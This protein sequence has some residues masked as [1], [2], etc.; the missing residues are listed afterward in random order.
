M[1]NFQIINNLMGE[2]IDNI[3]GNENSD[4]D[5][6][7]Q[8]QKELQNREK[9]LFSPN[10]E[11]LSL[12]SAPPT[13]MS[14]SILET[15]ENKLSKPDHLF[16]E[17]SKTSYKTEDNSSFCS[18]N[19]LCPEFVLKTENLNILTPSHDFYLNKMAANL[20]EVREKCPVDFAS[21]QQNET[22]ETYKLCE[23][24]NCEMEPCTNLTKINLEANNVMNVF[25][26]PENNVSF[27]KGD[28]K[29]QV[30]KKCDEQLLP[31]PI[32]TLKC[33]KPIETFIKV[34]ESLN[35]SSLQRQLKP[36]LDS[37]YESNSHYIDNIIQD[38]NNCES[39][40]SVGISDCYSSGRSEK[41]INTK[42][43]CLKIFKIKKFRS[44]RVSPVG[45][46]SEVSSESKVRKFASNF[47]KGLR[48]SFRNIREVCRSKR[49]TSSLVF[50]CVPMNLY[51]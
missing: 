14:N 19:Q 51:R 26:I 47:I 13:K 12:T 21:T 1:D 43:T 3:V 44:N 28:I 40:S 9:V 33:E 11:T 16:P 15:S 31:I 17:S 38:V 4:H 27:E 50:C 2:M 23:S 45:M 32:Q 22:T 48:K 35:I 30:L 42:K 7:N 24:F 8:V 39:I 37:N 18:G 25:T 29:I 41:Q 5:G 36:E 34:E 6:I 10:V 49:K 46:K 20:D